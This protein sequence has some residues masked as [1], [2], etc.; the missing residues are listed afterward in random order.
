MNQLHKQRQSEFI[1]REELEEALV[2]VLRKKENPVEYYY[3]VLSAL[4]TYDQRE[5]RIEEGR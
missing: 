4:N 5:K 2:R 1:T 3:E